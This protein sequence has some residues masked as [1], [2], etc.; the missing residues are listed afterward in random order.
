MIKKVQNFLGRMGN[1]I[2]PKTA[3]ISV[4][5]KKGLLPFARSLKKFGV[6]IV[7]TGGT[8]KAL[9]KGGIGVKKISTITKFPE[10]FGGRVKTLNPLIS[11]G[12]LG[13][14]DK[15]KQEADEPGV[16]WIDL[17]V[18]NLYPFSRVA[19][20]PGSSLDD[21]IEN[22]DIGGPTMIRSAAKN[23]K[24]VS[25]VV[26][27]K[28][29]SSFSKDLSLGG[30]SEKKRFKLSKKAFGHC[31]EYDQTIFDELSEQGEEHISLRY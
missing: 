20:T 2:I 28:D 17:V 31:A 27:H 8:A 21:K 24:W 29:Y 25:V 5:D 13:Q 7:A 16:C 4:S 1:K 26:N 6:Q 3:L 15:D 12:I 11:G 14:R 22:I 19:K 23:F 18:C 9:K 10:I 30:V